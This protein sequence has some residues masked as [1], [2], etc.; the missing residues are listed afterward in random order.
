MCSIKIMKITELIPGLEMYRLY[1]RNTRRLDGIYI[2]IYTSRCT[3]GKLVTPYTGRWYLWLNN[4][5]DILIR[6]KDFALIFA[7]MRSKCNSIYCKECVALLCCSIQ[8][9]P[10]AIF[11]SV[12]NESKWLYSKTSGPI[13]SWYLIIV[14]TS[15]QYPISIRIWRHGN[16]LIFS[17]L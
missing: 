9:L 1:C 6:W 13:G 2:W 10:Y 4:C 11:Y 15:S 17:S 12:V 5:G 3:Q 8:I 16:W 14:C 7:P